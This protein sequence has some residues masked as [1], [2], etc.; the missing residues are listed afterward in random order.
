MDRYKRKSMDKNNKVTEKRTK[1][2]GLNSQKHVVPYSAA[3]GAIS[4][5]FGNY[6]E[7]F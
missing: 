2:N 3:M 5:S 4:Y 1:F 7:H 6:Y